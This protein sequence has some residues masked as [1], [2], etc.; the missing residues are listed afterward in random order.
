MNGP[1][2]NQKSPMS[3][4]EVLREFIVAMNAW[5]TKT[6][7]ACQKSKDNGGHFSLDNLNQAQEPLQKIYEQFCTRPDR[8]RRYPRGVSNP[9]DYDPE[10]E[11]IVEIIYPSPRRAVINTRK[12]H[13]A[14]PSLLQITEYVLLKKADEWRV[15]NK[16]CIS[17]YDGTKFR[18][19]L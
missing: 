5:E 9:S 18:C 2:K 11:R 15:D 3:P 13:P 17:V 19:S 6:W 8:F 4:E 1:E 7:Q 12:P 16:K 14:L 10:N